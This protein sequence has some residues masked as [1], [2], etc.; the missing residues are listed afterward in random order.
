MR[1]VK[2]D[3]RVYRRGARHV[4]SLTN[5]NSR[6]SGLRGSRSWS[7]NKVLG[8]RFKKIV[9]EGKQSRRSVWAVCS[10]DMNMWIFGQSLQ[11]PMKS[12]FKN[13]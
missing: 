9:S 5:N 1:R 2:G 3:E 10:A 7:Q 8:K 11:L 4:S 6:V 13:K 12:T